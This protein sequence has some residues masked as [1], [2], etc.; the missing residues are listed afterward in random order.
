MLQAAL[1]GPLTKDDHAAVPVTPEEI[2]RDAAACVAAGA[3]SIHLHPRDADGIERVE[4][5]VVD[6]VVRRVR[7]GCGAEISVSTG[8]W[9]EPD[10]SRRLELIRDWREPDCATV[11]VSDD[12]SFAVMD[13][14]FGAGVAVEAGVWSVDDATRLAESGLAERVLRVLVE[15]VDL[16]ESDALSVV[17]DIHRALDD[18][19]VG[20]SRLQHGDG[21]ATWVLIRDA[22]AR[23]LDT[24]VGLEDTFFDPD[25]RRAAGNA[26][27]IAA[28]RKLG[29]GPRRGAGPPSS[30]ACAQRRWN[31]ADPDARLAD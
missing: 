3:R 1:N 8:A 10:L 21:E 16:R 31:P 11:N 6:R 20:A 14:L 2:A 12:G 24:R 25:G 29:A 7:A 27:L 15:P 18:L 13:A 5:E 26:A 17:A 28:A 9:I 30:R 4:G 19:G 22:V 23:G